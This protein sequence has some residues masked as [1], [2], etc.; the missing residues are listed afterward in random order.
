MTTKKSEELDEKIV[1]GGGATGKAFV[2][3]PVGGKATL[4][5]SNSNSDA[6]KKSQNP[7]NTSVEETD[8]ENNVKTDGNYAAANKASVAMKEEVSKLFEGADVTEE[9]IDKA[10]T[11]FEAA[12][13]LR[14][15]KIEEDYKHHYDAVLDEEVSNIREEL[16]TKVEDYIEFTASKWL[17][18]NAVAIESSL[19]SELTEDFLNGLKTL[20]AE[21][22]MEIPSDKVDV[23]ENLAAR[24]NSLEADVNESTKKLIEYDKLIEG[25]KKQEI[26]NTVSEGLVLTQVEKLKTIAEGIS[27]DDLSSYKTKLETLKESVISGKF[28]VPESNILT[29]EFDNGE[30]KNKKTI[31]A[32]MSRYVD[33]ITRTVKH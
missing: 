3:E 15:A 14:V 12:I 31:S 29:E 10:T 30:D 17:E 9:F 32:D 8:D 18:E 16:S 7:G 21:N 24:V 1:V 2:P 33:A 13:I 20:F 4:P 28:V 22:Y 23:I 11:I 27:Y 5:K 19:K 6:M 25:Y 26:I